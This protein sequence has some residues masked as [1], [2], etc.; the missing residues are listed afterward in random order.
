[1]VPCSALTPGILAPASVRLAGLERE[2]RRG[3][4]AGRVR[5]HDR[6]LQALELVIP[7][8]A[9]QRRALL[10]RARAELRRQRVDGC[11]QRH[12]Q[13]AVLKRQRLELGALERD[14]EELQTPVDAMAD[15]AQAARE[16]DRER[17]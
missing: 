2:L 3:V 16:L 11:A 5:K 13:R 14:A 12:Q 4:L 6:E 8:G 1:S 10:Q 9:P 15:E 7:G 17:L